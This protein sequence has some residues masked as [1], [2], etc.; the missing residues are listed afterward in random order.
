[1]ILN[2]KLKNRQPDTPIAYFDFDGTLTQSDT[3]MPFLQHYSGTQYYRK[4]LRVAPILLGY[5][6]KI[7]PNGVVKE[8]VLTE[9]LGQQSEQKVQQAIV[10]QSSVACGHEHLAA[11]SAARAFLRFGERIA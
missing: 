4:L 8:R 1:M 7:V 9:F 11:T 10:A 2:E 6:A 5:L 3:L